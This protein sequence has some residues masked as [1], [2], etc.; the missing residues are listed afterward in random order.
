VRSETVGKSLIHLLIKEGDL[1]L[2]RL[3]EL[4]KLSFLCFVLKVLIGRERTLIPGII[5]Y[6]NA[7][8]GLRGSL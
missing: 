3:L 5:V 8:C 1:Q 2:G 7:A 4:S 6:V